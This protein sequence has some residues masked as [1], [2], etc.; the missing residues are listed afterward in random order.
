[1][2]CE[3]SLVLPALAP[4]SEIRSPP[5]LDINVGAGAAGSCWSAFVD[6]AVDNA[7]LNLTTELPSVGAATASLGV[8]APALTKFADDQFE[9]PASADLAVPAVGGGV[10]YVYAESL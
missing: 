7:V 5:I 2:A 4:L 3:G 8:P 1:M 9:L 10:K 6:N